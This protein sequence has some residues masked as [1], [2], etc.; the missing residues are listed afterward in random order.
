MKKTDLLLWT[1]VTAGSAALAAAVWQGEKAIA[2]FDA[3]R[4]CAGEPVYFP[5]KLTGK[6]LEEAKRSG[7]PCRTGSPDS[8]APVR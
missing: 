6:G 8:K 2:R 3:Q 1:A 4:A 7:T 5:P